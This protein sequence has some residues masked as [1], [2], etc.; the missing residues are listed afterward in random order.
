MNGLTSSNAWQRRWGLPEARRWLLISGRVRFGK[1]LGRLLLLV[2]SGLLLAAPL[3]QAQEAVEIDVRGV[4]DT[5]AD[6]IRAHIGELSERDAQNASRVRALVREAADEALQALGYF[7]AEFT[8]NLDRTEDPPTVIL[9]VKPG[10]PVR[11]REIKVELLGEGRKDPLLRDVVRRQAPTAGKVL[12]QGLYD[13]L[14][15][16]LRVNSVSHGYFDARFTEQRL[17]IDRDRKTADVHLTFDTGQRY[18]LGDVSFS[19]TQLSDERL[20][21]L[22]QFDPG[23]PYSEAR[24]NQLNKRLL[25]SRYFASISVRPMRTDNAEEPIP[26]EVQ[27]RDNEPNRVSVGLGYGT[28][29]GV[30]LRLNWDKP[31]I[32]ENGHSLTSALVLS[33]TRNELL[34][35]YRI[36]ED[37]PIDDYWMLQA[38]YLEERFDDKRIWTQTLGLSRQTLLSSGW[39]RS[40]FLRIRNERSLISDIEGEDRRLDSQ[41]YLVPGI[42]F[43]KTSTD[44][45]IHPQRGYRLHFETEFSDPSLGSDTQYVR[46]STDARYLLPLAE[47]HQFLSRLQLGALFSDDFNQ[48]PLSVRF[49]AG[50]DQSIR[51]YDYQS[52]SPRRD[53]D[54]EVGGRYLAVASGEYLYRFLPQWQVALFTDHGGAFDDCCEPRFTGV[55]IGLRWLSPVGN[56]RVDVARALEDGGFRLHLFVGGVL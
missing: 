22:V 23:V 28:D 20:R 6:N 39:W 29:T 3:V 25:D 27:L 8:V 41:L 40:P 37:D 19:E 13:E 10:E 1:I 48:V 17:A 45:G 54:A 42:S 47:R 43:S 52:L 44:G 11:W 51:G 49:F 30:R 53:D 36:P 35:E 31:L 7:D 56:V 21:Q 50:G 46:V 9:Q 26:V 24:I 32:T 33:E 55:G 38:G 2:C 16:R 34:A 4:D 12:D 5:L 18:R 15:S 14:K